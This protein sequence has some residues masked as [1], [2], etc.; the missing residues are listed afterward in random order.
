MNYQAQ[1]QIIAIRRQVMGYDVLKKFTTK[2]LAALL[3]TCTLSGCSVSK[4]EVDHNNDDKFFNKEIQCVLIGGGDYETIYEEAPE[5]E[6]NTKIKVNIIY[7]A[8]YFDLDKKYK[9]DFA[10]GTVDYDVISDHSSFYTQYIP[11]LESLDEY[12]EPGYL[13][14]FLP[15]LLDA[16]RKDGYLWQ[17][18][19][20]AD[21]SCINY[22]T[23]LFNDPAE[24][25]AFKKIY[26][27][28][29]RV[30][31]TWDEYVEVAKFFS[32][33][34]DL[35]GTQFP[36]KE[37][38]LTGRFY[39]ILISL[40]GEFINSEG[41]CAFNSDAGVKAASILREL[42]ASNAIPA[43]ETFN[44]LWDDLAKNFA[45]R[46]IAFYTEF[47]NGY[48]SYFQNKK[49]SKVAGKFD[50]SR[51][52]AGPGGIHGG[53]GGTHA[54][55]VTR[56]SDSK[57]EAVEFIKFIASPQVQYIEAKIG[58][59]PV[60]RSIWD[61]VIEEAAASKDPLAKKRLELAKLQLSEDFFTP[62]LIPEWIPASNLLFPRLQSII[63]GD[64]NAKSALDEAAAE[65]DILLSKSDDIG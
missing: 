65:I 12:L 48:Y 10:A 40:G 22:R 62:P 7:K 44:Y 3:F 46:K 13:N 64:K 18:P 9:M 55:S 8:N 16:G 4:Q 29:L 34:E 5:F 30:P 49:E 47:F 63:A 36:G 19:R 25:E 39:E 37:E 24:K 50:L 31:E 61:K 58:Y 1:N 57:E 33:G 59:L 60:R 35:Y 15:R 20:H 2:I 26:N 38:A 14:D 51:Q 27:R 56:D 52:P 11:Y 17:I 21:I 23:D 32:R 6:K 41:K 28:E 43:R 54:F 42:Y 45:Q 53:W